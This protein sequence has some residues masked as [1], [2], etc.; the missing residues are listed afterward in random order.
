MWWKHKHQDFHAEIEAHLQ[1]EADQLR[2][3]GAPPAEAEAAARRAFGNRTAALEQ[4]YESGRWML[5]DHLVRDVRFAARVFR[6]DIR[7]SALAVLGPALGLA[8]STAIF[9]IVNAGFRCAALPDDRR[10][11]RLSSLGILGNRG[12]EP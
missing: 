3:E 1:L 5:W 6:R 2:A 8:I 12:V 9:A 7:F 4:F 10:Y 11:F